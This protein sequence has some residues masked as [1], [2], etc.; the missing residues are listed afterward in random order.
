VGAVIRYSVDLELED[1]Y[2]GDPVAT[3]AAALLM[4]AERQAL[5]Q[6][7]GTGTWAVH[8]GEARQIGFHQFTRRPPR[9]VKT[10]REEGPDTVRVIVGKYTNE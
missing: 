9:I 1:G 7:I 4:L 8:D 2:D 6:G 5:F 3:I 10:R